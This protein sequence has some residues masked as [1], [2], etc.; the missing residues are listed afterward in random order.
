LQ[1]ERAINIQFFRFRDTRILAAGMKAKQRW[2]GDT[3]IYQQEC[4][5]DIIKFMDD[6][7]ATIAT[8]VDDYWGSVEG[9]LPPLYAPREVR[10][11]PGIYNL[12][13]PVI[14][15]DTSQTYPSATAAAE[16]IGSTQ[17]NVSMVCHGQREH[18][19]GVRFAYLSDYEAGR[20]PC[21]QQRR[22]GKS[23]PRAKAVRCIDTGQ[24]FDTISEAARETGVHSGKIV[25]VCKATRKSAGGYRWEY[26][27]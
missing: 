1:L 6:A 21:F 8:G 22:A 14:R 4:I 12:P 23:N 26:V 2:A 11:I 19:N 27:G 24:V 10:I 17:A 3:E 15:L 7:I 20:I 25:A 16:A 5:A 18:A 13:K 9:T